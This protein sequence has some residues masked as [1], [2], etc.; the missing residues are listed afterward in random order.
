VIGELKPYAEYKDSGLPWLGQM[1]AHWRVVRNGSLFGQRSQTGV[2]DLPI[3]E[4]SLKTGV[5]VRAFGG[6]QRKQVMSDLAKYKRAA[7]G[8]L[9]YNTMR[10][11]Q[12]ALG[13]CPADGL[14]SPAYVVARPFDGVE[15][16][17]F[18]ALFR[19]GDYMAE[20]DAA[21]RGIV[22]DRNRLYW[23][24]FKQMRSACPP[25]DEQAAIVRFLGW[26]NGR[27][28]RVIRA[29]RKVIALLAEQKQAIVQRAVN[30]G[31]KAGPELVDSGIPGLGSV[32][33]HWTIRRLRTLVHRVDQ[34]VSPL[35]VGF[36]ADGDSWGVLKSGCVNRGVI[37]DTEHKR[38]AGD[39]A[40]DPGIVVNVG[41]V[42]ISRACG[43]PA[44]VGSV[45]RVAQLR[46][47]L[48]LSDKTFRP[49][50]RSDIDADFMVWAMNSH[51]YRQQVEQAISGAEGMANNLPL[52]SLR[53]FRFAL[54]PR[55]EAAATAAHL[56]RETMAIDRSIARLE[57]EIA[58]LR[59]YRT[60]LTADVVTGQLDVRAAAARLPHVATDYEGREPDDDLD[61]AELDDEETPA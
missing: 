27:L 3:L 31:L 47:Q 42:L 33:Q 17:Y 26:A 39:F 6:S 35:A 46:Y 53:D 60:R 30:R 1:P 8:D 59:E 7:K 24:Q 44:L 10:M 61:E 55:E 32:P 22:K 16:G 48:I 5:Q 52:S 45:G 57:R 41:D 13:V 4:V 58:Q 28:E 14:V 18:A 37:R 54:P 49:V 11:W 38:L 29:K 36:L 43:T 50:F 34:G 23:D 25:Q 51:Y 12:G 21:S 56:G 2:A 19:T 9:A 15:P 20:I 40:I